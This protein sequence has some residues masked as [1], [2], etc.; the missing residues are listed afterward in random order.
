MRVLVLGVTGML[1]SAVFTILSQ[2]PKLDVYGTVRTSKLLNRLKNINYDKI[3]KN[4]DVENIDSLIE[5]FSIVKP[6]IV[7]NCIGLIKQLSDANDPL[8]AL[9]INSIL[10]HRLAKLC[11]VSGARLVHYSTDCV[12]SG[13]KGNYKEEDTP[14]CYDLYGKSKQI[15]EVN[16]ENSI[17][18]R[19]SVIGHELSSSNSLVDWFLSQEKEVKGFRKAIFSGL[20]TVEHAKVLR[21]LVIPNTKLHGLYHLAVNPIDKYSLL[22]M[23]SDIYKKDIKI[24][25]SDDLVIDRSLDASRFYKATGYNAPNWE[26]LIAELYNY[27]NNEYV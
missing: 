3:L 25:P 17:T 21:N 19:T 18:L 12:F 14:D 13:K 2:D 9:P 15:G 6:N 1:G 22:R 26:T 20:T 4:T 7:I 23:V 16:Y 24:I 8:K 27:K 5:V 10:P 11:T